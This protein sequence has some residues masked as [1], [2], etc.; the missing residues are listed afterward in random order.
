[1][2]RDTLSFICAWLK[3]EQVFLVNQTCLKIPVYSNKFFWGGLNGTRKLVSPRKF[4][5]TAIF[6][7]WRI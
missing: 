5:K 6:D 1:M 4:Y 7:E 2:W 3:L